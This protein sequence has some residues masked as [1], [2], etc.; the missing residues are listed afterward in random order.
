MNISTVLINKNWTEIMEKIRRHSNILLK[1]KLTL[2]QRVAY[3]NT[4]M[5]SKMWYTAHIYPLNEAY[6]KGINQ[7]IFQYIWGG[8]YEPI[9][10][11]TVYR[12]KTE[13]GLA[14]INCLIKAKTI[15]LNTFLKCYT[16]EDYNNT[17][18]YY[19]CYMR[20]NNIIPLI[21]VDLNFAKCE[22][23]VELLQYLNRIAD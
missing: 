13:G 2:H 11:T 14:I 8:R 20:L 3:A 7:I 5:M 19:Y 18:M 23:I 16:H 21:P 12:P 1:R 4:C 10:R 17:L 9:R 22:T 6:A 15:M